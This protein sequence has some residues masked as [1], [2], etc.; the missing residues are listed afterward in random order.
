MRPY[1]LELWQQR[2]TDDELS[3]IR[4]FHHELDDDEKEHKRKI[5]ER[6]MKTDLYWGFFTTGPIAF[7]KRILYQLFVHWRHKK[8]PSMVKDEI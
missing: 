3:L 1:R 5:V 6:E 8:Q 2:L 7:A 4:R